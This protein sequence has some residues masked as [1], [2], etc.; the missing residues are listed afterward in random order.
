L[1]WGLTN[2]SLVQVKK[3]LHKTVFTSSTTRKLAIDVH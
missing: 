2:A 3:N 1:A